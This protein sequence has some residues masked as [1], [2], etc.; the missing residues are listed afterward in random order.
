MYLNPGI[1]AGI[2]PIYPNGTNSTMFTE[3]CEVAICDDQGL[4]PS[5][6]REVVGCNAETDGERRRIRWANATRNWSRNKQP[7]KKQK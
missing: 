7:T 1:T 4:C 3:C 5:C 2:V 6:G